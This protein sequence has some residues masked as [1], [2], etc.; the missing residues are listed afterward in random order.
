MRNGD[1]L[2]LIKTHFAER[3]RALCLQG[4]LCQSACLL[5]CLSGD[6]EMAYLDL[7]CYYQSI[8]IIIIFCL[9]AVIL[10]RQPCIPREQAQEFHQGVVAEWLV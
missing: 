2:A 10:L 9:F 4:A 6:D 1:C 7:L 5:S 3:S 8:A